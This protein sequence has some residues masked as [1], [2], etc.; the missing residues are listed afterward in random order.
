MGPKRIGHRAA[1]NGENAGLLMPGL[2]AHSLKHTNF[3]LGVSILG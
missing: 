2:I 3:S 1:V